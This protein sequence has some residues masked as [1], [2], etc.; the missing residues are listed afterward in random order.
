MKT[1]PLLSLLAITAAVSAQCPLG[2]TPETACPEAEPACALYVDADG[3]GLCDNPGSQP[4]ADDTGETAE[5]AADSTVA[6]PD[7][8][9][10]EEA[11]EPEGEEEQSFPDTTVAEDATP[12]PAAA[13]DTSSDTGT[14]PAAEASVSIPASEEDAASQSDTAA[15]VEGRLPADTASA[16]GE[17]TDCPLG[18]TPD[19]ACPE[20]DPLCVLFVDADG[21]GLCDNPGP[22]PSDTLDVTASEDTSAASSTEQEATCCPLGRTPETAC[23]EDE[24]LCALYVDGNGDGLC[25]NPFAG[26]TQPVCSVFVATPNTCPLYL[27]AESACPDSMALCPHWYGTGPGVRCANPT[28][29]KRRDMIVLITLAALLPLATIIS[30]HYA[31]RGRKCSRERDRAHMIMHVLSL[32]VLGFVVQGCYCPLG[33]FQYL[34]LPG[35][36]K[37]LGWMGLAIL[38]LPMVFAL[39]WGRVFCGWVCPLGALQDLLGRIH[40]PGKPSLPAWL[41][42]SL[43]Y[44]KYVVLAGLV[45]YLTAAAHGSFAEGSWP[46]VF[47]RIDPFHTIFTGFLVG[48]L[49]LAVLTIVLSILLGRFFCKYLCF[50]GA[51]LSLLSRLRLWRL[52][53]GPSRMA[54]DAEE[55]METEEREVEEGSPE[56]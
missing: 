50:Y 1:L 29:G 8:T 4:E 26:L 40:V 32:I 47:C 14:E 18:R 39:F 7:T 53:T 35:G 38:L 23:P 22:Q 21:D 16:A 6:A 51:L 17:A 34:F 24:P 55:E 46:A 49:W 52:L 27:N 44:L 36:L 56:E 13:P 9:T 37:F 33:A 11:A 45:A 15:A 43:H 12:E 54:A 30:R 41:D 48:L 19:E 10:E 5:T 3:D 31:C 20:S 25:D 2:R 42:K 28:G